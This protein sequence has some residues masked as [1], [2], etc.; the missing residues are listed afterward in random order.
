MQDNW[1]VSGDHICG[2]LITTL[3]TERKKTNLIE[4]K[5]LVSIW[6]C[7]QW[8][9]WLYINLMSYDTTSHVSW[10]WLLWPQKHIIYEWVIILMPCKE[11]LYILCLKVLYH[12]PA[13]GEN[14]HDKIKL[15]KSSWMQVILK[16]FQSR[17]STFKFEPFICFTWTTKRWGDGW[18]QWIICEIFK[19]C[20]YTLKAGQYN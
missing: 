18:C 7:P 10:N 12:F 19:N 11:F 8:R 1:V 17:L 13:V 16:D 5:N 14:V 15:R 4:S 2:W 3:D 9:W 20:L 6:H